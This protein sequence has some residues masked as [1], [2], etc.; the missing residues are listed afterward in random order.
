MCLGIIFDSVNNELKK[1]EEEG[2]DGD[3][4]EDVSDDGKKIYI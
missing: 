2:E 3:N 4:E 1:D